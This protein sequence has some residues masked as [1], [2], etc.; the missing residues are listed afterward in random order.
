MTDTVTSRPRRAQ[1]REQAS[2]VTA[3][4]NAEAQRADRAMAKLTQARGIL[5][6]ALAKVDAVIAAD[7]E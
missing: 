1:L 5:A 2:V 6:D 7:G 3:S 4:L